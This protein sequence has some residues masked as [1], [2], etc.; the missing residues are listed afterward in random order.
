MNRREFTRFL[1]VT[2]AATTASTILAN[3]AGPVIQTLE[4][5]K[6]VSP[7]GVI[8]VNELIAY[9]VR[10]SEAALTIHATC[11]LASYFGQMP[12]NV[13]FQIPELEHITWG[14]NRSKTNIPGE[15]N[16]L[17][18]VEIWGTAV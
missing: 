7:G 11:Y 13:R 5:P 1:G 16:G 15:L 10:H 2:A 3:T 9:T 6:P 12:C 8:E 14:V 18:T 17:V 4:T